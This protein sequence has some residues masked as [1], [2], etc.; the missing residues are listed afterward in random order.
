M[1]IAERLLDH[2]G[3]VFA[4]RR[5]GSYLSHEHSEPHDENDPKRAAAAGFAG[6]WGQSQTI[7][8]KL[9]PEP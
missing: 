6:G 9:G 1:T 3:E 8:T 4:R 7:R 2:V 5:G